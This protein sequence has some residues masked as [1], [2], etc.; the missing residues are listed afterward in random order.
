MTLNRKKRILMLGEASYTLSGF[1]T[2]T[3]EVMQRLAKTGKYELAELAAYAEVNDPRDKNVQ[4]KIYPNSV[5]PGDPRHAHYSS[6]P[7]N[8][9]GEWRFDQ[10]LLD[11]KPDIVWD[12][13]DPWMINWVKDSCLRPYF[14]WAIMPTVDSAPQQDE[15]IDVF[16]SAD[17]VFTYS[18]W[19]LEVLRK[20]GGGRINLQCS[21]PPGTSLNIFKPPLNKEQQKIKMGFSPKMNIIGTVMRNQRRKLYPDLFDSFR[22]FLEKCNER[23][24]HDIANNTYLF[25]HTSYPDAGWNMTKILKESGIGQRVIF[26]YI[27]RACNKWFPSPFQDAMGLCPHCS[28]LAGCLPNVSTGI[29]SEQLAEIM[30]CF[31]VYVQLAICEGFGMPQVEAAACGVPVMAMPYS[32]MEDIVNKTQGIPLKIAKMFLELETQAY[33]AM[34][35]NNDCAE[36]FIKFLSLSKAQQSRK[37]QIAR[38]ACEKYF[39]YDRT[40]KIW[41]TYFDSVELTGLQGMWDA[42]PQIYPIPEK[43]PENI[44]T[45]QFMYWIATEVLHEP[46]FF[47]SYLSMRLI[48]DINFGATISFGG[49]PRNITREEVFNSFRNKAENRNLFERIRTGEVQIQTEDFI[50]YAHMKQRALDMKDGD[51]IQ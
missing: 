17:G 3:N 40:A 36:Q 33:R 26:S 48:N 42:P 11:F 8:Q 37:G 20:E 29:P 23:G 16:S 34:P 9:F 51:I 2:Y 18:D 25:C 49:T 1:G 4:W 30:K 50:Q 21:A 38:R 5:K 41:E 13:R 39:N 10:V 28:S 44:S 43:M 45:E 15:W 6:K 19:S 31:D 27:C 12:I 22:L 47:N 7:T 46:K 32:A 24:L 14:H 35:D